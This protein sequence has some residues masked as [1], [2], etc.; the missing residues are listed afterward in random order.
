MEDSLTAVVYG[1]NNP[2]IQPFNQKYIDDLSFD[3]MK[4]FY[5]DRFADVSNFEFYIVGDVTPEVLKPLL[6]K[7]IASISGIKRKEKFKTDIPKWTSNKIDRDIFI[8]MET[9]KSS[10]RIAF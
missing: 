4:A 2:R 9:P 10:V 1:K 6:E 8:K 5:L 7:Y 3:K